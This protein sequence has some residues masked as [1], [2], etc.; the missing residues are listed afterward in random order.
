MRRSNRYD[1][2]TPL[3]APIEIQPYDGI[4]DQRIRRHMRSLETR[5]RAFSQEY[6]SRILHPRV[7]V[8]TIIHAFK[9]Y[10]QI[11]SGAETIWNFAKATVTVHS[12]VENERFVEQVDEW[13][14]RKIRREIRWFPLTLGRLDKR[15]IARL[16]K[17]RKRD[18]TP[19]RNA[20]LR[21]A[22]LFR[23]YA[24]P[25]EKEDEVLEWELK[26]ELAADRWDYSLA[27]AVVKVRLNGRTRYLTI[28]GAK[29][30]LAKP[31]H[32]WRRH[33][34][35]ALA[36][37]LKRK[38]PEVAGYYN[39]ILAAWYHVRRLRGFK[40]PDAAYLLDNHF[41]RKVALLIMKVLLDNRRLLKRYYKLKLQI[42]QQHDPEQ[43]RMYFHDTFAELGDT[44]PATYAEVAEEAIE[45]G[46]AMD[47]EI[48][49][50]MRRLHTAR[51]ADA[52]PRRKKH[53][54]AA[55]M[56]VAPNDDPLLFEH[57]HGTHYSANTHHHE[58]GHWD[59]E[60]ESARH[61][62]LA[63]DPDDQV[64]ETTSTRFELAARKRRID[65][66]RDRST[67]LQLYC[68]LIEEAIH[69]LW[70]Y[71]GLVRF[72]YRIHGSY[73]PDHPLSA[74]AIMDH[75]LAAN[76]EVWDD[77]FLL[78]PTFPYWWVQRPHLQ[79]P[80]YGLSYNW[81]FPCGLY[82]EGRARGRHR[83]RT[84]A[85]YHKLRRA[86]QTELPITIMRWF[87]ANVFALGF[88][89]HCLRRLWAVLW[90]AERLFRAL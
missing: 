56:S 64:A 40:T 82:I 75:W 62:V 46:Q 8:R 3:D 70:Q 78:G 4:S 42:L 11:L 39:E 15:T 10:E 77:A 23:P 65:R 47:P 17:R 74:R 22:L 89:Q 14:W 1:D 9:E 35:E 57:F 67:R 60:R 81:G 41:P 7:A 50:N 12:T 37:T 28:D 34:A 80:F 33:A 73:D 18:F 27:N 45:T 54:N 44:I 61:G 21:D 59:H 53:I 26:A 79:G 84:M 30:F 13:F 85:T 66:A 6:R 58:C 55:V 29:A 20:E 38:A 69:N 90:R 63:Q 71:C 25:D 72:E 43:K 52:K 88:W 48:G 51:C 83:E 16:R 32:E 76:R 31:D 68:E 87:D 5:T 36:K 24:L 49:E 19:A 86:G 2:L